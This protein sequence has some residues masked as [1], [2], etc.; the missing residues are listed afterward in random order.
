MTKIDKIKQYMELCNVTE[1]NVVD[2]G[3]LPFSQPFFNMIL[4]Y[5]RVLTDEH[6][7]AI[8]DQINVARENIKK[9]F[10]P[11]HSKQKEVNKDGREEDNA[12]ES[13]Q[14]EVS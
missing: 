4:N 2:Y 7:K 1:R 8:Y 6:E 5:K 13:D 10:K 9:G 11:D 12:T 3:N 14:T